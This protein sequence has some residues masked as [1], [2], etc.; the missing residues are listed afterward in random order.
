VRGDDQLLAQQ[1]QGVLQRERLCVG[2]DPHA[3][4]RARSGVLQLPGHRRLL[5]LHGRGRHLRGPDHLR[6]A[7]LPGVLPGQSLRLRQPARPVRPRGPDLH[8]LRRGGRRVRRVGPWLRRV[9]R[10]QHGLRPRHL[11]RLLRSERDLPGRHGSLRVRHRR[12]VL[13]RLRRDERHV[14]R[15]PLQPA[16]SGVRSEHLPVGV[17]RRQQELSA[18][19]PRSAALAAAPARTARPRARAAPSRPASRSPPRAT[20]RTASAA[21]TLPTRA[22]PASSTASAGRAAPPARTA[23]R[24]SPPRSAT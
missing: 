2:H 20:R 5:P 11:Q 6:P 24:S 17:L 3:V 7:E 13:H 1:L 8:R 16:A 19:S 21:A 10:V 23:R 12:L 14:Q 18:I 15:G 22:R 4:R 9:L